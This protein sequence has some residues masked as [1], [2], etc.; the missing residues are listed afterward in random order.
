M[1]FHLYA[2]AVF[3]V[4]V[5]VLYLFFIFS[6]GSLSF[7]N[8]I[9]R[10]QHFPTSGAHTE[11]VSWLSAGY[12]AF[13]MY[14]T[15][16]CATRTYKKVSHTVCSCSRR[17]SMHLKKKLNLSLRNRFISC[18]NLVSLA[19]CPPL[20]LSPPVSYSHLFFSAVTLAVI[21]WHKSKAGLTESDRGVIDCGGAELTLDGGVEMEIEGRCIL[22]W[23]HVTFTS[24]HHYIG[25]F[26]STLVCSGNS[27]W[28]LVLWLQAHRE[29][30]CPSQCVRLERGI[31][32]WN[33]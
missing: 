15:P 9:G 16:S 21:S 8:I 22:Y 19:K 5:S 28:R 12:Y 29:H 17:L 31:N 30:A 33:K 7:N 27:S 25:L 6:C 3:F 4:R 24:L 1:T 2:Q 13:I 14:A 18:E 26:L 20:S 23:K 11:H 32:M 10:F